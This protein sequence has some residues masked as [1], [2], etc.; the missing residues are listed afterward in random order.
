MREKQE[1]NAHSQPNE[2]LRRL[3][4]RRQVRDGAGGRGGWWDTGMAEGETASPERLRPGHS[5]A[6]CQGFLWG[7]AGS[8]TA[9]AHE[10]PHQRPRGQ[11]AVRSRVQPGC[12]GQELP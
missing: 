11:R 1:A 7:R 9:V 6:T 3:Q 8:G 10:S 4:E 5:H 12:S 2:G